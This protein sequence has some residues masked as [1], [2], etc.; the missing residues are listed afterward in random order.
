MP[1]TYVCS[2]LVLRAIDVGEADRFCILLT[3]EM[4]RIPARVCG[5]RRAESR[6][7]GVLPGRCVS[8]NICE[9]SAG[10]L[11]TAA[12][13]SADV[14]AA[15]ADVR[16]FARLSR[17]MEIL[18][19]VLLEDAEPVVDVYDLAVD[20]ATLCT[21]SQA[22]PVPAFTLRL[23]AILG[24]LPSTQDEPRFAMLGAEDRAY[25]LA[26]RSTD[27]WRSCAQRPCGRAVRRFCEALLADHLLTPLRAPAAAR[28]L[29]DEEAGE[30]RKRGG[31]E[32]ATPYC[33]K[34]GRAS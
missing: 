24:A 16:A 8:V 30:E 17:G 15:W 18:L 12:S 28:L 9:R 3:R 23:L 7:A 19:T 6:M 20:F 14:P 22:D 29:D 2:A 11:V 25:I 5:A 32:E 26:C 10:W 4:G 27:A 1:R 33:V 13:A 34:S 31:A 21:T